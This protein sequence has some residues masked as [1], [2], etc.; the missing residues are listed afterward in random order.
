M[1]SIPFNWG[2]ES[3][4]NTT[5]ANIQFVPEVAAL[6]DGGYFVMWAS[7]TDT[8]GFGMNGQRY[9]ASGSKVGAEVVIDDP[10]ADL[11]YAPDVAGL[12]D[13]GVLATWTS[14]NQDGSG[15]GV[16]AQRFDLSGAR[17][18]GKTLIN[19]TTANDQAFSTVAGLSDGSYVVTWSSINS[20]RSDSDVYAQR[21][22]ASGAQLGGETLINTITSAAASHVAALSDGGYVVTYDSYE[23]LHHIYGQRFDDSGAKLGS[24]TLISTSTTDMQTDSDIA[25]LSDGGY[26]VTWTSLGS[27]N[28]DY[29]VYGQRFDASGAKVGGETLINTTTAGDQH[30]QSVA[31]L[32]DGGYTVAWMSNNQDYSQTGV[33]AQRFDASGAKVGGETLINAT[34]KI[35]QGD[36]SVAGLSDGSYVVAWDNVQHSPSNWSDWD[37]YQRLASDHITGTSGNDV[38]STTRTVGIQP[39]ATALADVIYGLGGNDKLDGGGGSDTLLGGLGDDTYIVDNTADQVIENPGEGADTVKAAVSY[40]LSDNVEN[41]TLTGPAAID[42]TGN[43]LANKITG[44]DAANVIAGSKGDD[45][46]KGLGGDDTVSGGAGNDTVD[47][48]TG[49][50]TLRGGADNDTFFVDDPGDQVIENPGEGKDTVKSSVSFTLGANVETLILDKTAGAI[51]GTG[52]DGANTIKGN[53]SDNVITGG[54]GKDTLTGGLGADT[55]VFGAASDGGADKITDFEH[56]VDRLRFTG[57]DYG[58]EPGPLDADHLQFGSAA[59]LGHAQF[60]Y[61]ADLKTLYW[62]ADGL[63]GGSVA[64]ANFTTAVTLTAGDFWLA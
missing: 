47:G 17:L 6:T 56:G 55:F 26:F 60:L 45:H 58:L 41:L 52:N 7:I 22:D 57:S 38:I 13:G 9:D 16:F 48:G 5:T 61:D 46:L 11:Q 10:T 35:S 27:N 49:A 51:D 54:G 1:P 39:K 31:A 33:Y 19:T 29:N 63:A 8:F 34:T 3:R 36:P 28:A 4:V 59:S 25:A 37:V 23:N 40:A 15:L 42:G 43:D 24:E 21:F 30:V 62:D 2:A 44:N 64:I 32:G 14:Y 50:D 53:A 12:S 18:G 20:D